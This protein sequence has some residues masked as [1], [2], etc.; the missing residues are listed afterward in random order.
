MAS[1]VWTSGCGT[2]A[3]WSNYGSGW[4]GTLGVPSLTLSAPPVLGTTV[5]ATVGNSAGSPALSILIVGSNP[6]FVPTPIGGALLVIPDSYEFVVLPAPALTLQ[7]SLPADP[8]ACGRHVYGQVVEV[9]PGASS[10][11]A[12][13]RGIELILGN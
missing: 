3:A 13:S 5:E 11:Y 2:P 8:S 1:A 12:F 9:D 10:G 7:V 6:T 4:P